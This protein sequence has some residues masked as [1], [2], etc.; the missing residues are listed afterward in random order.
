MI[1]QFMIF[2]VMLTCAILPFLLLSRLIRSGQSGL[3][4][5][6]ASVIGA[7]FAIFFY[8][9]GRPFGIDPF[10]AISMA[11]LI[12]VPALLGCAAGTLLGWILRKRDDRA[13]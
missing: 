4:L 9:S 11:M 12:C 10:F 6:I 8:A 1:I 7:T 5:S 13:V 3:A 2:G